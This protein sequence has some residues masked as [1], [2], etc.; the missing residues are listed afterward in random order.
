MACS[1]SLYHLVVECSLLCLTS[2][3]GFFYLINK[4]ESTQKVKTETVLTSIILEVRDL[5]WA[6][7]NHLSS[8]VSLVKLTLGGLGGCVQS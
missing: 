3:F 2:S 4:K 5:V 1:V 7:V 6:A 8:D